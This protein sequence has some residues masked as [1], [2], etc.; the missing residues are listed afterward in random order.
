MLLPACYS[1]EGVRI[2]SMDSEEPYRFSCEAS[3]SE[4]L[5]DIK[6][7]L[8]GS[9]FEIKE[10]DMSSGVF[11]FTKTLD[12]KE[13]ISTSGFTKVATGTESTGQTGELS[14]LFTKKEEE[15]ISITMEG[16]VSIQVEESMD[17]TTE[18]QT[19]T[20]SRGHPL[21]IRYGLMLDS[22][23]H[24]TLESPSREKI[25]EAR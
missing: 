2:K 23:D 11:V 3:R 12:K 13:K 21:M 17:T 9:G 15:S 25:Q 5:K 10:E 22:A 24:T 7:S 16:E 8:V 6:R 18:T 14:F 4:C 20:P 1:T 19:S